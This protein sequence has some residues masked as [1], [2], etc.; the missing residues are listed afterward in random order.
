MKALAQTRFSR[1][2][3]DCENVDQEIPRRVDSQLIDDV[4]QRPSKAA[5]ENYFVQN[6][7]AEKNS[8]DLYQG[9]STVNLCNAILLTLVGE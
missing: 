8:N 1:V 9:R 5:K 4:D 2:K 6:Y 7:F 3:I